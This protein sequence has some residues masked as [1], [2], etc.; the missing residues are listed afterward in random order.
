M[1]PRTDN[2]V[3]TAAS[4]PGLST[5]FSTVGC[6][7]SIDGVHYELGRYTCPHIIEKGRGWVRVENTVQELR[8]GDMFCI[9]NDGDIEYYDDPADPWRFYWLH[10]R[11]SGC[12]ELIRSWNFTPEVPWRSPDEPDKILEKFKLLHAMAKDSKKTTANLIAAELFK[13]SDLLYEPSPLTHDRKAQVIDLA[14]ALIEGKMHT[15]LNVSELA[16]MMNMDRTTLFK[17]FKQQL[18]CSPVEYIRK[19]RIERASQMLQ[20][21]NRVLSEI[22]SICGF[23]NEKYFIRTF[24][25]LKGITP[26]EFRRKQ[27]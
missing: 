20:S 8:P 19:K 17:V 24:R 16:S 22:A 10:L 11:G 26:G 5:W 18:K 2:Y 12:D 27:K 7:T 21:T 9:M 13:L 6:L 3:I 14:K 25:E 4:P 23:S 1:E 15:G